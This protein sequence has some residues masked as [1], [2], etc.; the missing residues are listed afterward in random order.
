M[1]LIPGTLLQNRY[2]VQRKL[3]GGGMGKVYLA[4]DTRL[5]G[6]YCA[7][8]EMS[9]A[10]LAPND[11]NWAIQAFKQ[12]AQLLAT[13]RHPGLAAVTD[14]FSENGDWYLVMEY[15][16]GESLEERLRRLPEGRL[17]TREALNVTRQLCDVLEYL[18][19]CTP[20]V[21]FRDLKPS[22]VM[23]MSNGQVKVIDF[24]IARFF[25]Q[26]QTRDTLNM[27]TPGYAAPEQYGGMGQT[28]PRTDVYSL[29][30]VLYRMVT[31]YDPAEAV[32]PFSLPPA[33]SLVTGIPSNVTE[34]IS[35]SKQ[36]QPHLR[37]GSIHEMRRVLFQPT[38]VLPPERGGRPGPPRSTPSPSPSMPPASARGPGKGVWIGLGVAGLVLIVC[39]AVVLLT[40]AGVVPSLFGRTPT[41]TPPVV[42]FAAPQVTPQEPATVVSDPPTVMPTLP[43]EPTTVTPSPTTQSATPTFTPVA[44]RLIAYVSGD[45][46]ATDIYVIEADGRNRRCATCRSCDEAEPGWFPDGRTIIYQSDCGGSYDIWQVGVDGGSPTQI[47]R[48]SQVDEREPDCSPDGKEIVFRTNTEGSERNA[49]GELMVMNIS[50]GNTRSLHEQGRAPAWSPDGTRI[51]FMSE[52]SSGWEIYIYDVASRAVTRL[53]NCSAN[54]RWPA[55]SPDGKVVIY[56]ATTGASSTTADTI[57]YAP[58]AGGQAVRVVSGENAGRPSWSSG[59]WIVFNSDR[60]I[61]AVRENGSERRTVVAGDQNWAPVWAE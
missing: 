54:C 13:L 16:E 11:R 56:H 61:E 53:T 52:R 29:G 22:N 38:K 48:T 42:V 43:V 4:E 41:A 9:P 32:T 55:W 59:G 40:V 35:R 6:L 19:S 57:W 20:P 2:R 23:V 34:V 37:Y 46:G 21:I 18:H 45:V 31:G 1:D 30:V 10:Q 7:I 27:G 33:E 8:K 26:G 36:L 49:D 50:N 28:D 15:V 14:F 39:A 12:E 58:V 3:G 17:P 5:P 51:V 25:K 60:G 47:T 44:T 24:G